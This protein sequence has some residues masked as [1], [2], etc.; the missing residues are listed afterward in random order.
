MKS[1]D[2]EERNYRKID[3]MAEIIKGNSYS[4]PSS[5]LC[6]G[7]GSGLE[8]AV[9]GNR[10]NSNVTGIDKAAIFD[11]RASKVATLQL[12]DATDMKFEDEVFDFV[13]PLHS[14]KHIDGYESFEY[15]QTF[16]IL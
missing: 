5:I 15:Q 8:A 10:L 13:F 12:G 6:V 14:L 7:C 9:L 11:K 16:Q 3:A 2:C 4:L 1:C